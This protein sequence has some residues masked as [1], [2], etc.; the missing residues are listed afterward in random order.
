MT[1][2]LTPP[3]EWRAAILAKAEAMLKTAACR[4]ELVRRKAQ[5]KSFESCKVVEGLEGTNQAQRD[6]ALVIA[7]ESDGDYRTLREQVQ[8]IERDLARLEAELTVASE[9]C[10]L[11]YA[12]ML[13]AANGNLEAR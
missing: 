3:T 11:F 5:I 8:G 1:T 9:Y 13:F 7:L 4:Q 12:E 6:A 10:R 2:E